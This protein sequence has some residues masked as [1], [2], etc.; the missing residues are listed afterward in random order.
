MDTALLV[1]VVTGPV[2]LGVLPVFIPDKAERPLAHKAWVG[3]IVFLGFLLAGAT[4][5]QQRRSEVANLRTQAEAIAKTSA[6]VSDRVTQDL[7]NQYEP[8][9]ADLQKKLEAQGKTVEKIGSSNIVT[10]KNPISVKIDGG[11]LTSKLPEPNV[12]ITQIQGEARPE[13]GKKSIKII[14]STDQVQDGARMELKC[15]GIVNK[16]SC[17]LLGAG[18]IM[19]SNGGGVFDGGHRFNC[20]IDSPNWSPSHPLVMDIW[21]D[22]S[23]GNCVFT[24][25]R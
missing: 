13:F 20:L 17:T 25:L 16:V 6:S 14:L 15:S 11:T 1:I 12:T 5:W 18:V 24:R 7:K 8:E 2:L 10:G 9:I 21:F 23:V 22:D 4:V 19:G 3:G